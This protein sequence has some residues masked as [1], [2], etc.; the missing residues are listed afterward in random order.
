MIGYGIPTAGVACV[1]DLKNTIS[2]IIRLI[3]RLIVP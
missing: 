1:F 2:L 3:V